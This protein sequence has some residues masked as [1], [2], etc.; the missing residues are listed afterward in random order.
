[1]QPVTVVVVEAAHGECFVNVRGAMLAR[2]T[3][4]A[5]LLYFTFLALGARSQPGV[6]MKILK[7]SK[8]HF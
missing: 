1:M 5:S 8:S 4:V 7:G 3:C 6:S 2:V